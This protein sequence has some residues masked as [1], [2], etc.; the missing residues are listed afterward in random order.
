MYG[1]GHK[2]VRWDEG[3]LAVS[4]GMLRSERGRRAEQFDEVIEGYAE[5]IADGSSRRQ[6]RATAPDGG[7]A[8]AW[9]SLDAGCSVG[10]GASSSPGVSLRD[11]QVGRR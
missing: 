4:S 6:F 10:V 11:E 1:C 2:V 7:L 8:A 9:R 5:V 3:R